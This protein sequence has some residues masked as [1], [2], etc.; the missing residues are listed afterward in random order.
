[1]ASPTV[2]G[3]AI[4]G[5]LHTAVLIAI[6]MAVSFLGARAQRIHSA[7]SNQLL[8]YAFMIAWE[9]AIV[10]YIFLG[11]RRRGFKLRDLIGGKWKSWEDAL[12]DFAIA[13]GFWLLAIVV[14]YV[15][16]LLLGIGGASGMSDVKEKFGSLMPHS[17]LALLGF[18]FLSMTA[19]F[20]EEI[21]FRG[22]LQR[23]F[24]TLTRN[25]ATAIVLQAIFF[26]LGHGYQ[27]PPRMFMLFVYGA[28]FGLLAFWRKS[29]RAGI[30]SHAWTDSI[31]GL[32]MYLLFVVLK[33]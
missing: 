25:E 21:M 33:K 1:M 19:G 15:L 28:M 31:S 24:T 22:Y 26:G 18:M 17:G 6:L 27:G 9:W 30:I 7:H 16:G 29:L 2:E 3:R 32:M 8:Q 23:Q 14:L 13:I 12:L 4:A 10:G 11:I 20:C 5:W